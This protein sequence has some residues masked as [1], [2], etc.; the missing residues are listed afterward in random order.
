MSAKSWYFLGFSSLIAWVFFLSQP[1]LDGRFTGFD[2]LVNLIQYG[3]RSGFFR[4]DLSAG[5]V[6]QS[7][8]LTALLLGLSAAFFWKGRSLEKSAEGD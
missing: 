4:Y 5:K 8:F 6:I 7:V 2:L 3:S 1:V